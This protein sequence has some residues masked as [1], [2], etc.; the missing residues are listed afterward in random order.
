MTH[1][2]PNLTLYT[3]LIGLFCLSFAF[4]IHFY[5]KIQTLEYSLNLARCG[6]NEYE[7]DILK[8][9]IKRLENNPFLNIKN[10]K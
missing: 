1:R 6:T 8:E 2:Q 7:L 3:I 9:E 5:S 10:D 4:N